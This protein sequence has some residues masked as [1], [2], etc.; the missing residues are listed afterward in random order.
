MAAR[1]QTTPAKPVICAR[2]TRARAPSEWLA[3]RAGIPVVALPFTV[4]GDGGR[5]GPVRPVRRHARPSC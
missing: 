3:Q 2:P 5:E 1:L 4:G